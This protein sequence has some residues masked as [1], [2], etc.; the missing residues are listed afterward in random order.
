MGGGFG[1]ESLDTSSIKIQYTDVA[2]GTVSATQ[3]MNIYLPNEGEGPFPVIVAI[4]GG[5]FKMGNA[6]GGDVAAMFEGVNHGYAVVSIN[7]RLSDE[8]IF[9]A[10][11]NDCKAA[12]R[13]I[14]ANATK[15]KINPDKIAV[16]G[17]SAGGNLAAMVGTTA[18]VDALNGDNKENLEYSSSVQAVVD[19]FGPL[20]FLKMD[21]QF[22]TAG[23]TPKFGKTS[24]ESSPESQY[25]GQ[26][27]TN[28]PELTEKANPGTYISTINVNTAPNFLIQHGTA[29][30]NVPSQQSVEFA[31]QLKA[32]IGDSKV[33]LELLEGAG[34]GTQEFTTSENLDKV[35]K[36]LDGILK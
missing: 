2:Y 28:N 1:G 12:I 24:S 13:F 5:A 4:H 20:D 22:A 36:F 23:I 6:S 32:A 7:Y 19:W 31:T 17:D 25:I 26:L 11:V 18:N 15:Y 16:W 35:F 3:T 8:A 30:A 21:E 29:D 14:K 34:H 9:P 27:I 10:A 33:K